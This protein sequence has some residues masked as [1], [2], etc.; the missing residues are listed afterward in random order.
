V[1]PDMR[2]AKTSRIISRANCHISFLYWTP[3]AE[4]RFL[5]M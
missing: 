3:I 2:I 5:C 1:M 4:S